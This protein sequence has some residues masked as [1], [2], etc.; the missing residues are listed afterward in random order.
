MANPV[1]TLTDTVF[2][3]SA[4]NSGSDFDSHVAA[5]R[6]GGF[7]I[8]ETAVNNS[9]DVIFDIFNSF[10]SP[11]NG[12][13]AFAFGDNFSQS[14][15]SIFGLGNGNIVGAWTDARSGDDE[16][17]VSVFDPKSAEQAT[18]L[19]PFLANVG[20]QSG[21][22][23]DPEVTELANGNLALAWLDQT[24][25][26]IRAAVFTSFGTAITTNIAV[27]TSG[28]PF[29]NVDLGLTALANGNFVVSWDASGSSDHFR[30]FDSRG[31][32]PS[33]QFDLP[34][35]TSGGSTDVTTLADG[36]F[37]VSY[38]RSNGFLGNHFAEIFNPDG[39]LSVSEFQLSA[40]NGFQA[41]TALLDDRFMVV[42]DTNGDIFGRIWNPDGT[43]SSDEFQVNTDATG[44]QNQPSLDTLADGRVVVSWTD[45]RTGGGDTYYTIYDPRES[46][47]SIAGTPFNDSYV[48][49]SYG[50]TIAGGAGN[51]TILGGAGNDMLLGGAG[52]DTLQGQAGSDILNGGSGN[53]SFSGGTGADHFVI[54]PGGDN[55]IFDFTAG[56]DDIDLTAFSNIHSFGDVLAHAA[57][58][59]SNTVINF[60]NSDTLTL[61]FVQ[62]SRLTAGDFGLGLFDDASFASAQ[63]GASANAGGWTSNDTFPRLAADINGDGRADL[64][65]FGSSGAFV[66]LSNADGSFQPAILGITA[67][68]TSAGAGGWSSNNAFPRTLADVNGDHRADIIGFGDGG[69]IVALANANGTFQS[70]VLG[71]NAFGSSAA[72]GGWSSF[73]QYPRAVADVNGDGG[74]DIV[75]FGD[76]GVFVALATGGGHFAQPQ[77]VLNAFGSSAAAGGWSSFDQFPRELADIN[78]DGR[79]DIVGFGGSGVFVALATAGGN[80]AQPQFVLN[81]FGSSAAAGSWSSFDQFPR[82]VAEVNG[83]GRADIVGFGSSNVFVS[84]GQIDGTFGPVSPDIAAFGPS[85]G[86]WISNTAYPRALADMNA[87][88]KADIVAFGD[89]GVFISHSHGF[90][91]I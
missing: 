78:G 35:G 88:G 42:Y 68:G 39:S 2:F 51:D 1:K 80:F 34:T 38:F 19:P 71:I 90:D 59:G 76:S 11:T 22:Q 86:G 49:S 37:V 60:G 26:V 57:Q 62:M 21:S 48:G 52:D 47:I 36:R 23:T 4:Q 30:I 69:A 20:D 12:I 46:G 64:L 72:A 13:G 15:V 29:S 61:N 56:L 31:E 9:N 67:F 53:N 44:T 27:S 83:D 41:T 40:S 65:G 82:E 24:A 85:S 32:N 84:L 28:S 70:P 58:V 18:I 5:L 33:A 75:G 45:S 17:F 7:A 77:M 3:N 14:Q 81:S 74:A 6:T 66:S 25:G 79:A 8:G 87:D 73:D 63:F 54:S 43:P 50:D 91:L 16:I 10:G 89:P 55:T